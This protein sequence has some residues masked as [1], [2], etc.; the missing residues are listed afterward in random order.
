MEILVFW[1]EMGL[2]LVSVK[3]GD[4]GDRRALLAWRGLASQSLAL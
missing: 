2:W 4:A 1:S 3:S